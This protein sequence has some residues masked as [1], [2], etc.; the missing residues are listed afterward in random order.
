[1][2]T[3]WNVKFR[4]FTMSFDGVKCFTVVMEEQPQ[5]CVC[6][7]KAEDVVDVCGYLDVTSVGV[8]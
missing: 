5:I 1:M 3:A 6:G 2:W 7:E 8:A 4:A